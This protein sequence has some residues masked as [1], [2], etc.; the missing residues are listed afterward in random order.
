VVSLHVFLVVEIPSIHFLV[1]VEEDSEGDF[2]KRAGSV[3]AT[4]GV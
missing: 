4:E 3:F 2:F 1:Y